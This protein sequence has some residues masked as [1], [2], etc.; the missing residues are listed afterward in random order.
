M[1]IYNS[2][3]LYCRNCNLNRILECWARRQTPTPQNIYSKESNAYHRQQKFSIQ[4]VVFVCWRVHLE[5]LDVDG[6]IILKWTLM[7][8]DTIF[9]PDPCSLEQSS[10][11]G[12]SEHSN[13]YL[14]SLPRQVRNLLASWGP[15]TFSWIS[16]FHKY[17]LVH[18]ECTAKRSTGNLLNYM[19]NNC[20]TFQL[21]N[22]L[23][24]NFV[25][26]SGTY[27]FFKI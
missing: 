11:V 17:K 25:N 20:I 12:S 26:G 16:L 18:Q 27:N 2:G 1:I 6:S 10:V 5:A 19:R 4:S 7:E 23:I 8:Q 13:G 9:L 15:I 14:G 21:I 24:K 22:S 3:V